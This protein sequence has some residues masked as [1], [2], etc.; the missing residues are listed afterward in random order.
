[1]AR[2]RIR[3][4]RAADLDSVLTL[5]VEMMA[6]HALLDRRFRPAPEGRLHYSDTLQE[7]M[8]DEERRVV[9]AETDGQVVGYAVGHLAENPPVLEPHV[10]GHVS[11]ICVAPSWRRRG[12]AR[13]LFAALCKWLQQH[14]AK[15]VQLHV[16]TQNP[17][18]QA[19][20]HEMG[21][22]P[23]MTRMWLDLEPQQQGPVQSSDPQARQ[24]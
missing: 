11:D 5:W 20:W 3:R 16:A 9:V 7:W 10:Y 1:M 17:A 21:F 12:I 8:S 13:L 15:I 22:S 24:A 14:G 23:F 6:V 18:A 19:F 4:A 2:A